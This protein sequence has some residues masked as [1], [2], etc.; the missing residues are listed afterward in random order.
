MAGTK[1]IA[2]GNL[3]VR[4]EINSPPEIAELALS[5]NQMAHD[6]KLTN[7]NIEIEKITSIEIS[8]ITG[9]QH[10]NI[11]RDIR[12]LVSQIKEINGFTFELVDYVDLKGETRPMYLLTK[13]DCLLLSSVKN[14]LIVAS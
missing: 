7:S 2:A 4:L 6:L 14:S 3:D 9:K 11:M 10:S 13:K 12:N 5:F 1:A 8:E